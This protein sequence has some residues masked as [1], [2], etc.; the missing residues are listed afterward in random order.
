M[1]Y[2]QVITMWKELWYLERRLDLSQ[3]MYLV[4]V[5]ITSLI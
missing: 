3:K 2:M 1:I 4:A 5:Q